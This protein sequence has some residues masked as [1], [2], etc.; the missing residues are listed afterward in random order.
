LP[1]ELGV[2]L[3]AVQLAKAVGEL[4]GLIESVGVKVDRLAASELRA[5]LRA[6]DQA[7]HS[8]AE[9]ESLLREARARLNKAVAI[10][11]GRELIAAYLALAVTHRQLGDLEN[12]AR[13]LREFLQLDFK[14]TM[15]HVVAGDTDE[16]LPNIA[17]IVA[18][19]AFP[20]PTMPAIAWAVNKLEFEK[21]AAQLQSLIRAYLLTEYPTQANDID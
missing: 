15:A 3:G 14:S 8:G 10:E 18:V 11:A 12:T 2:L 20:I 21:Q 1:V 16:P 7:Q 5:G 9:H 13:V 6:L 17:R 19:L 4:T